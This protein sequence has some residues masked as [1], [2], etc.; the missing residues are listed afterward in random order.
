[1]PFRRITQISTASILF[2]FA[3]LSSADDHNAYTY[4]HQLVSAHDGIGVRTSGSLSEKRTAEFISK[5]LSDFGY[6]VE[7]QPFEV[8]NKDQKFSSNNVI[9][10]LGN[11]NFPTIILGAHYDS[12]GEGSYGAIDNGTGTAAMLEIAS[13]I[14]KNPPKHYNIRFIAFGAEEI[15]I[16]G[17][18]HYVKQLTPQALSNI[19]GMINFDMIAGGDKMYIHSALTKPYPCG[20]SEHKYNGDPLLR[21][22]MMN[23][24][25]KVLNANR[26]F[27]VHADFEGYPE[28]E[29]GPWSDHFPF[30]CAGIPIAFVES[31]NFSINGL[32]GFDGLS[33]TNNP[34]FWDCFDSSSQGACNREKEKRW[35][36]ILHTQFDQLDKIEAIFPKRIKEQLNDTVKLVSTFLLAPEKY[37]NK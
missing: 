29:T 15:G 34:A 5:T 28:G 17:S 22:A 27:V 25:K 14:A 8:K 26:Q 9:A 1:M 7:I 2:S 36:I 21:H 6:K 30:S 11:R 24:S 37:L 18:Q 35:G 33:Q 13:I 3:S 20:K 4:L 12:K 19:A 10:E 31:T 16:S 23:T 32:Y